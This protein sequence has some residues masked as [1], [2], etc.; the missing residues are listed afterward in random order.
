MN[1]LIFNWRDLK[2]PSSGGAEILTHEMAKR[3]AGQNHQVTL[4]TSRFKNSKQTEVVDGVKIVRGGNPDLRSLFNSVHFRAYQYYKKYAQGRIDIVIDEMHGMPF[5]TP[6][7]VKEKKIVLICEVAHNVWD[8]VFPFPWNRI[9]K[10]AERLSLSLYKNTQFLT[11]SKSTKQ[12]LQLH[13]IAQRQ[14]TV[15]PMG[16]LRVNIKHQEKE[17]NPTVIYVARL[18]KMKGIEDAF[19]AMKIVVA[20][21]KDAKLWIV[22]RGEEHYV[23]YLNTMINKLRIYKNV[24]FWN[25]I[26]QEKKFELMARSHIIISPSIREGFGLTIP[27]A[28]SVGT[29]AVAY[30]VPGLRDVIKDGVNGVMV[31][32]TPA[33]LARGIEEVYANKSKYKKLCKGAKQESEQYNWDKTA[34]AALKVI[35]SNVQK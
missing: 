7:Y 30:N 4:F 35:N 26:S 28:G 25:F 31:K 15:L 18:N 27:E 22:G 11:I 29:P 19:E 6:L 33:D 32:K 2:N 23:S 21:F 17:K 9:G 3:M 20:K 14:I 1:I 24:V 8:S 34:E 16:I 5:F 10:L 13:G 12:D